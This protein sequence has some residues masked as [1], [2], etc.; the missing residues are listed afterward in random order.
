MHE[1]STEQID[2]KFVKLIWQISISIE[3]MARRKFNIFLQW[4]KKL[5]KSKTEDEYF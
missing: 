3:V 2:V 1:I 4:H 5:S